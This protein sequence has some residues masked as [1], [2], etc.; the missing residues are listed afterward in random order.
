MHERRL[1]TNILQQVSD[2]KLHD[3]YESQRGKMATVLWEDSKDKSIMHGFTENYIKLS[4]P[5][6]ASLINVFENIKID[7]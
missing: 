7:F 4:R 2:R 5:Y 6:D 1:R 3:F